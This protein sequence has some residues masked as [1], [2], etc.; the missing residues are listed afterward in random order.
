[1][2]LGHLDDRKIAVELCLDGPPRVVRGTG[3]Y[4]PGFGPGPALRIEVCEPTGGFDLILYEDQWT[5][6]ITDDQNFG[7][8]YRIRLTANE[9]V[10]AH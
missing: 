8:D 1:M 6:T 9:L 2:Y 10:G 4:E 7:C 3:Y 5:G